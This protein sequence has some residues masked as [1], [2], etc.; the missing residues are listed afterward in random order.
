MSSSYTAAAVFLDAFLVF[1]FWRGLRKGWK[2]GFFSALLSILKWILAA[3]V[4]LLLY[5]NLAKWL[6]RQGVRDTIR[7]S[8]EAHF[9]SRAGQE[10]SIA[11][12]IGSLP[13]PSFLQSHLAD[14]AS[15][16]ATTSDSLLKAAQ[17]TGTVQGFVSTYLAGILINIVCIVGLFIVAMLVL[18]VLA[19]VLPVFN[20]VPVL[21][22]INRLLGAVL[23]LVYTL[24]W[25]DLAFLALTGLS[26]IPSFK[27]ASTTVEVIESGLLGRWLF[28]HNFLN[29]FLTS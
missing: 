24:F 20:H 9:E 18:K 21:G 22:K 11:G 26:M 13:L 29:A 12:L 10:G 14:S 27:W 1:L 2:V 17:D 5:N 7:S 28:D 19:R 16:S 15:S 4:A 23:M 3:A 8:L 25:M 6:T